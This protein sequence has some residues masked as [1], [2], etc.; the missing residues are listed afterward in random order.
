MGQ[1]LELEAGI[2]PAVRDAL[3]A[4]GHPVAVLPHVAGGMCGIRFHADGSLEGA[5]C[6]RADGTAIGLGG[7]LARGGVRFWPDRP[8]PA[9]PTAPAG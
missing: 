6:W 2:A 3:G 7:G 9:S 5:A 4:M 8:A 1:A